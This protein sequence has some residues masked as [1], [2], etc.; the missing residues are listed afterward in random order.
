M[1]DENR[2][3]VLEVEKTGT[4]PLVRKLETV[5]AVKK[6]DKHFSKENVYYPLGMTKW[7]DNERCRISSFFVLMQEEG[8]YEAAVRSGTFGASKLGLVIDDGFFQCFA[9]RLAQ[10]GP[11][12]APAQGCFSMEGTI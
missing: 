7:S 2:W 12:G 10:I 6:M 11:E 9:I 3:C 5:K 8:R 1:I 4:P